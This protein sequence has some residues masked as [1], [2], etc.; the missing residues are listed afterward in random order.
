VG[1][2][3]GGDSPPGRPGLRAVRDLTLRQQV[4]QLLISSFDGRAAPGYMR[5]RLRAKETAGVILFRG[6]VASRPGLSRLTRVLQTSARG[7]ALVAVDQEGGAVRSV[8]FAGPASG[9]PAQ[10]GA[11]SVRAL[12]R[13]GALA[14]RRMGVNVN[15]APVADVADGPALRSRAFRGGQRAVSVRVA[16]AVG[17]IRSARV[18]PTAKHFPGLGPAHVVTDEAPVSILRSRRLLERRDVPPF[19]AALRAGAPLVMASHALYAALDRHRIASQSRA[20]LDGL[21]RR[22]LRFRGAVVTDSIE[23]DAVLRRSSVAV[24]AERSVAAGA[25]LVLMTGSGSWRLVFP[26]LLGA[27][28]RSPAFRARVREAVGRVLRLKRAVG[29]SAR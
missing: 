13:E 28:R 20:I 16:A 8:P 10:G 11:R 1:G 2:G 27:A 25:D 5:R 18:A 3:I 14:L 9:Q 21:L 4:G 15:L 6:N 24:A 7:A 23:A 19:R 26:R 17:G 29:L 22:R 12:A